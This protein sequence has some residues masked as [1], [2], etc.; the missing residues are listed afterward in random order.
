MTT[1]K[2]NMGTHHGQVNEN[3]QQVK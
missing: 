1:N 3:Q 2:L